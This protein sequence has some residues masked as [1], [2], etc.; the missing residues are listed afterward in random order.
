MKHLLAILVF[1][2]A[3]MLQLWFAPAGMR[4][5]FV[6]ATLVVFAFLFAFWELVIFILLGIFLLNSS[7][8]FNL[9]MLMLAVIPLL[10]YVIRRR[11]PLDRWFGTAFGIVVSIPIFYAVT[12]PVAAFHMI[13][14]L[15]LD[16]LACVIFGELLLC[17]MG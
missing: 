9:A 13:G 17:G 1:I 3:L 10:I 7:P 8:Y 16:I 5:D 11:F 6:L 4:G 15:S 14:F 2:L 12:A